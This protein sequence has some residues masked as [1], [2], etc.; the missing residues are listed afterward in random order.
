MTIEASTDPAK[1]PKLEKAADQL[2]MLSPPATIGLPKPSSV[3]AATARKRRMA[4]VL[5]AILE[6][7]K[8]SAPASAEAPTEQIK[9]AREAAAASVVVAPAKA[10]PLEIAPI[11]LMEESAPEK[12]K[13]PTPE[14]PHKE[15]EFI[16]RHASGTQLSSEQIVE[17][18]H[19]VRDLKYPRGS[20]VYGWDDEE[21][22]L[23]CLLDNKEINVC[24][25]MMTN[26][27]FPKLKLGLS[28]M[29][30]DQLAN[31]LAFNSLKVC[32]FWLRALV[33]S[34]L[35]LVVLTFV[36]YSFVLFCRV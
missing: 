2:K 6:S 13:S 18:E 29:S 33:L 5:D 11:A 9:D 24:P 34:K 8:T 27:G 21:D 16:I 15:L 22:F 36:V 23:Y 31:S 12:S 14:E 30:K 25:K 20:L 3:S 7:I 19:Y 26:M 4:S 28:A 1:E 17:V 35:F 32:K 10:G